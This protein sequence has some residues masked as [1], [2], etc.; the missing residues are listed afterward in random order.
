MI[1]LRPMLA[2]SATELPQGKDWT[3]EVKWDGYR[4][5][6]VKGPSGGQL[7]SRNQ[8]N[9]TTDYPSIAKAINALPAGDAVLDGEVVALDAAGRPSFQALQHRRTNALAYYA[10]DLLQ[11]D[12]TP[13]LREPLEARRR[14]LKDLIRGSG[15][16]LSDVLP[17]S[18]HHIE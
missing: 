3:Y 2:T 6:A 4:A 13:L 7:I 15:I 11:V 14:R 1:S 12:G 5:L 10:F 18:P 9:L 17:G 16:L 8:K